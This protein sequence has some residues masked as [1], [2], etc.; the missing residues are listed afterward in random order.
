[1]CNV[2]SLPTAEVKEKDL[3]KCIKTTVIETHNKT[4]YDCKN[5]TKR[6]CT[7]LWS[8]NEAGEKVND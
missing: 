6:H 3:K 4:I 7:T 2:R 5:V 1:M 8:V